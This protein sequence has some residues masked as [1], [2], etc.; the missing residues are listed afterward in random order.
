M[1]FNFSKTLDEAVILDATEYSPEL[2]VKSW[3]WKYWYIIIKNINIIYYL[4]KNDTLLALIKMLQ[5]RIL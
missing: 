4:L 2:F 1:K 3:N 5:K